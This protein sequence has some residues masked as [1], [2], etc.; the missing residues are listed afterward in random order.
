MPQGRA[1][2]DKQK[3]ALAKAREAER[4]RPRPGGGWSHRV[5]VLR[6]PVVVPPHERGFVQRAGILRANGSYCAQGA[7][8]RKNRPLTQPPA[9]P[10]GDVRELEGTWLWGGVLWR[11]FGHFLVEST[12]R[13]WALP[14]LPEKIAGVLFIPKSPEA[15]FDLE[16]YQRLFLDMAGVGRVKIARMPVRPQKLFVPGQ[17]FGLGQISEGTPHMQRFCQRSFARDIAP[18]G[19]EK[20]FISRS[21]LGARRGK[22]LCEDRLDS[23]LRDAGYTVFHPQDHDLPTQ[24]ARYKAARQVI[25]SEGSAIHL[26]AMV[27]RPEQQLAIMVRR[28]SAATG[29]IQKH[30]EGFTGRAPLLVNEITDSWQPDGL[31]TGRHAM[32]LLDFAAAQQ[33]LVSAGFIAPG[34]VWAQPSDAE[35]TTAWA[36]TE[37]AVLA[38][39]VG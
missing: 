19:P 9:G 14:A 3:T 10:E 35:I 38:G 12:G 31:E 7:L 21:R 20:L 15:G 39:S 34:P 2:Q 8:W 23:Y 27:A 18:D 4:N 6:N 29:F 17:G 13:L 37:Q 1:E 11:H 32:G 36:A 30:V 25:A 24:I 22:L 33:A 28:L 26:F 5:E 16:P